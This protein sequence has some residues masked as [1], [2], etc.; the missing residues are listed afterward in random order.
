MCK[1]KEPKN[2]LVNQVETNEL[3]LALIKPNEEYHKKWNI[4]LDDFVCL[5][6]NGELLRNTLY[7]VGGLNNPDLAKDNYFMLLKYSEAYFS[8]EILK[9]SGSKEILKK[10]MVHN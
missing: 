6:K 10:P 4:H 3:Q 8:K 9:M 5:S 1:I 2:I 7:R